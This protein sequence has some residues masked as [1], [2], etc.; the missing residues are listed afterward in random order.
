[1]VSKFASYYNVLI[2]AR[3]KKSPVVLNVLSRVLLALSKFGA[4]IYLGLLNVAL[5]SL[6]LGTHPCVS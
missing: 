3:Y 6:H 5:V 1:M 4:P 2:V